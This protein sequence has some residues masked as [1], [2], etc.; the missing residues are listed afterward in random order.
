MSAILVVPAHKQG[1]GGGHVVRS[2]L[3]V[4][5]LRERDCEAFLYIEHLINTYINPAWCI[6]KWDEVKAILWNAIILDRFKT[7]RT[8]YALWRNIAPIIGIDEGG[9]RRNDCDFLIDLLP[10]LPQQSEANL[11][12]P[13][14]LPLPHN[15]RESFFRSESAVLH[16]LVSFGLEDPARLS[17]SVAQSLAKNNNATVSVLC[18]NGQAENHDHTV[19]TVQVLEH[20]PNLREHLAEYDLIVTH[21]GLTAF[22]ALAAQVP[23]ILVSPTRYHEKLARHAGFFTLSARTHVKL[24]E[25]T[26]KEV[27]FK[28]ENV[29][30]RFD[31][32]TP[33]YGEPLADLLAHAVIGQ[34]RGCPACGDRSYHTMLGRFPTRTF[35]KCRKC[36]LMYQIRLTLPPIEYNGAYFF[37][38]YQRQYG[39]TY[40]EDFPHLK[41]MAVHRLEYIKQ[42]CHGNKLMDIGCA[43]GPFLAAAAEAG[44]SPFGIDP[45]KDAIKYVN[46]VLNI[47]ALCGLFPSAT[48][49][50][51]DIFDVITL[52]YVIEHFNNPGLILREIY[53][54]L[55]PGGILAFSTPSFSG[56]SGHSSLTK[57]LSN[58]PADHW[59]I[60]DPE[61][62]K[63]I[64]KKAGFN[65]KHIVITGHHPERFPFFGTMWLSKLLNLGDTFE[66][67]AVKD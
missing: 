47:P 58:S 43:Y 60:W 13:W 21:F 3:L 17:V 26:L 42:L 59:T 32:N 15:R 29:A 48:L 1:Q 35:K 40:L 45:A 14:M 51:H 24:N 64:L 30:S 46:T 23:V 38:S 9:L 2:A 7:P 28:S 8:E 16:V 44:F 36:G 61:S 57:F 11:T 54:L 50:D 41:A 33:R 52:W 63:R 20:I 5:A 27:R 62:A 18:S 31:I 6:S 10:S 19:Q 56:I 22:E 67:Y 12:A 49:L 37:E 65:V 4:E 39:K 55:K 34:S 25:A 53:R 66:V